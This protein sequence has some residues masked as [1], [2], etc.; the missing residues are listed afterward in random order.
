MNKDIQKTDKKSV[1]I[2]VT[3]DVERTLFLN[4]EKLQKL[5]KKKL[6]VHLNARLEEKKKQNGKEFQLKI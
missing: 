1:E 5:P 6:N 4:L 3:G 2:K